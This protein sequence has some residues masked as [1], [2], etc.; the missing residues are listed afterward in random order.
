MR[1]LLLFVFGIVLSNALWAQFPPL[2]MSADDVQA[3][4]PGTVEVPIRAGTNWQNITQFAGTVTFDTT[5]IT[6]DQVSYWG[7]TNPSGMVFTYVGGGIL[8]Y[9]WSS[10][11]TIGPS[12]NN[13]DI[14]FTLKF[15]AVGSTGDISPVAFTNTPLDTYWANGFGWNGDNFTQ[16]NGSVEIIC[17]PPNAGYTSALTANTIC[18]TDTTNF[19]ITWQWDFGDG[20][21][22]TQQSPCHTYASPGNYTACAIISDSCTSDTICTNVYVCGPPSSDWTSSSVG[23]VESFTDVSTNIPTTWLWDFGDGTTS[24]TQ[25]P[26][27][28]YAAEGIYMV[29][30]TITNICGADSTCYPVNIVC[31]TPTPAWTESSSGLSA[32]FTDQSSNAI[33][34]SWDFGDGTPNSNLQNPTHIYSAP[35]TYT[36]CQIVTSPC[37]SDTLC[38]MVTITCDLPNTDWSESTTDFDATFTDMS[39]QSPSSWFWEFGDGN[40]STMQN[41]THTY[42]AAGS[43]TV[44]LTATN[45]CGSDSVC[46]TVDIICDQPVAAWSETSQDLNVT[47]SDL[48]T[49]GATSWFWDFGDGNTSTLQNPTHTYG[50]TGTFTV[51][52]TSTNTCGSDTS[53]MD[54]LIQNANIFEESGFEIVLYPNPV[55]DVLTIELPNEQAEIAI[56][57]VNN[58]LVETHSSTG[59]ISINTSKFSQGVYIVRISIGS[60]EMIRQF[61]KK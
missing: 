30:L 8:T 37:G 29:C 51:C 50:T 56:Y 7:L 47:F 14:I 46:Y 39:T 31:P 2:E 6:Y 26:T 21:T 55:S 10:L 4:A 60:N 53:C 27:H 52:L 36:V 11:I 23:L 45:S 1:Y 32:M 40:T 20:N 9:S 48:S 59:E 38:N 35:G 17:S 18:F 12:L 54:V 24:T 43:Y 22:S 44:C 15:N 61:V 19:A 34:W 25:N 5:I 16:T 28:L 3:T 42:A 49:Q 13:N 41:P 58:R 57:D 33:A